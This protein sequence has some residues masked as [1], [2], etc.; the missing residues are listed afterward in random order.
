LKTKRLLAL[1]LFLI[2]L[3]WDVAGQP[4]SQT[5]VTRGKIITPASTSVMD[6]NKDGYVSQTN[7]GFSN[8]GDYVGEFELKMFGLPK[9]G[10]DVTADNIGQSCGIT[11]LI[12]DNAGFSVYALRDAANN[13]IF[14]FRVGKNNPS[15]EAWTILLDTDG[16]F[17]ASDPN[18]TTDNPGFEIDLTLI[19]RQNAG[20]FVYNVD[21][22]DKCNG[23]LK[24]YPLSSNFQISVADEVSCGDADFFYDFYV[25]FDE[26]AALFGINANTGLRY[27]AVTNVSATCALDGKVADIS[28]VDYNDYKTCIPC[29]F[30]D[31]IESQCPTPVIDLCDIC[32]GFNSSLPAKPTIDEPIRAGQTVISGKSQNGIYIKVSIFARTGGTDLAPVW[33]ATP[34]EEKVV[35]VT[36]GSY[37]SVTLTNALVAYDKIVAKAQLNANGTGCGSSGSNTTS[38]TSVTVTKPNTRPI[39][40]D[41]VVNVIEDTPK[42]FVLTSSDPDGDVIEYCTIVTYPQHGV[43]TGTAP[44]LTYTPN[45]N[46]NGTDSF[47]FKVCDGIFFSN[48]AT[49]T[50]NVSPVNDAPV[51]NNQNLT[52]PEDTALPLTL[53]ATDP[54]G[55]ALTFTV[56]TQPAYGVLTGSGAN[57]IYTPNANYYGVDNFTFQASDGVLT[58]DIAT[59][60]ITVTPVI[61]GAVADNLTVVTNEDTPVAIILSGSSDVEGSSLIY[62]IVAPPAK[63]TLSGSGANVIYTPDPGYHGPDSFTYKV[64]DGT[65]DSNIAT[66]SITVLPVN[67]VPVALNLVVSYTLNTPVNFVLKAVDPDNDPLTFIVLTQPVNGALSGTA[68]DLTFT[69]AAGFN[70]TTSFTFQVN[71]GTASSNIA[72]VTFVLNN[73]INDTPVS[74][75]Q[76]VIVIEDQS[77]TIVLGAT[78]PDALDVLT[79]QIVSGPAHGSLSCTNCQS[80]VYTPDTHYNGPDSFTFKV[81]DG[82]VDS[83]IATVAITVT[84]VND[85]PIA[86]NLTVIVQK[87]IAKPITLSGS[88]VENDS[89]G[90]QLT[91]TIVT[92]PLHGTL[93]CTDC[94]NPTYTPNTG[95]IGPDSFTYSV[96]DGTVDS[97]IATVT[98][99][100]VPVNNPPNVLF[101]GLSAENVSLTTPEDTPLNFCYNV[102]DDEGDNIIVGVIKMISGGG[103]LVAAVS[104]PSQLCFLF[105]PALNFN[106]TAV[107]EINV[108]DD[109]N[110]VACVKST[111][112]ILVTPVNDAPVASN[113]IVDV[114]EDTPKVITLPVTDVDGD[115]LTYTIIT[116]PAHGTLSGTGP[117]LTYTPNPEYSGPDSFT[118]IANDG[119][120]DSN[121]GTI[122]INV[123][124]VNDPPVISF[125][126]VLTTPEDTP[127]Q[128]CLGVSDVEGNTIT[129]QTPVL[130]SGGGTITPSSELDFCFDFMPEK[131]FNGDVFVKFTVCDNGDPSKC[132]EVTVQ[133]IVT[134]VNDPP[135]AVNDT[136]TAQGS[137][138]TGSVNILANDIDVDNDGLVLTVTPLA[139]PYHGTVTMKPDGSFEYKANVGFT[140]A[141]SVRY[142]VCDTGTPTLCDEGVVFIEVEAS[143]FKIYNGLSPNG[144]NRNDYWRID[145]IEAFPNN[146]A[147]IFDRYNNLVFETTSYNND[148]NNWRGQVNNSKSLLSGNLPEGTYFYSLDL[149]DGSD[150]LSGYIV[151][152]KE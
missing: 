143:P 91:F 14:R 55:D 151:L 127:L 107:W 128:I 106:G 20:I 101:N 77:K 111:I 44:N 141:D 19:K 11:D 103:T 64:N 38:T 130:V 142:R 93:S 51:A 70:G 9:L 122:T 4:P 17:G 33:S 90:I 100:V 76:T 58:S 117:A 85:A 114:L 66:V 45:L 1:L 61:D 47:T 138:A 30:T 118:F 23:A 29:A 139:G 62:T 52:T 109:G 22:K 80:P 67:D 37:W 6:P 108:C 134:P 16:L 79:Y 71:D 56:I 28:G 31:I 92:L 82:T 121:T 105:T 136:V 140:G 2:T 74:E 125:I 86:G 145:G 10:G 65:S 39:A 132:T 88:D 35:Q 50:F 133:I 149:G 150:L 78:D 7:S 43:L 57:L 124:P 146:R 87:N 60:T 96:N 137:V 41:Q 94:S 129:Y 26:V 120:V 5:P 84:P 104:G 24:N 40:Y 53:T 12:P 32:L 147:R 25:P 27:V 49:V 68:P 3:G 99:S 123:I 73:L 36:L 110:P 119:T 112:S 95:Y 34:R 131:D 98:I 46:Y 144:D 148:D 126:P 115:P 54:D 72:T 89:T 113:I 116:P 102:S 8:D 13:L 83:N 75:N 152:K 18:A 81:N 42:D 15:V 63:G 21:G 97:N 59:I 48:T 69:P 135:I